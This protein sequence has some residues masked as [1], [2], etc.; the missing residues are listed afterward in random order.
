MRRLGEGAVHGVRGAGHSATLHLYLG[1]CLRTEEYHGKPQSG[2]PK[3]ARL[4]SAER[5][6]FSPLGHR[7]R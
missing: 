5:D 1:I 3:G 2:Y 4:N 6:S 7:G